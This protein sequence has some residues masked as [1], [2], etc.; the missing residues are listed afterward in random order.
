VDAAEIDS[1]YQSVA[2]V[3]FTLLGL[4]WVVVALRY[5]SGGG[6]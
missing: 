2:T 5:K 1:F 4:W 3:S 6:A